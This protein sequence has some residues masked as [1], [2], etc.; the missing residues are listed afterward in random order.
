[1]Q[2]FFKFE[3]RKSANFGLIPQLPRCAS[4]QIRNFLKVNLQI[5]IPQVSLVFQSANR[6]FTFFT[7]GQ[8]G[9]KTSF[10]MSVPWRPFFRGNSS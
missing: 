2:T 10:K 4:L 1:M 3:N 8:R 7:I 5:A 9:G 6:K